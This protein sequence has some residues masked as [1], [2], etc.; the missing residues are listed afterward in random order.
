MTKAQRQQ[1]QRRIN[2]RRNNKVR[3]VA[4]FLGKTALVLAFIASILYAS[5]VDFQMLLVTAQ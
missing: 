3:K 2:A 4:A 5:S 1:A